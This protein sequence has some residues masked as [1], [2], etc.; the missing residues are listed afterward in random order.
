M[1]DKSSVSVLRHYQSGRE[2]LL[3][4]CAAVVWIGMQQANDQLA[5]QLRAKGGYELRLIGDAYAPRRI[6]QA[7]REGHAAGRAVWDNASILAG[8]T[9]RG[10]IW[11]R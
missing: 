5:K 7:I 9:L 10:L 6:A 3:P 4:N 11:R 1:W 8:T 2:T